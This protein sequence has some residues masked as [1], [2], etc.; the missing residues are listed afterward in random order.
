MQF[1]PLVRKVLGQKFGRL[2]VI[3]ELPA[4]PHVDRRAICKCD[5]GKIVNRVVSS[6][7]A[8]TKK[9]GTA[10]CGCFLDEFWKTGR[11]HTTHG[12]GK[13]SEHTIW[14]KMIQR[15]T[16]END[17]SYHKYGGRGIRVCDRWRWSFGDFYA[18]MGPRPTPQHSIERINN[19][20]NYK[21]SNCRWATKKEQARNRRSSRLITVGGV[22]MTLAEAAEKHGLTIRQLWSRLKLGWSL[23][24]ALSAPLKVMGHRRL[25]KK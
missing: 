21:P 1:H 4:I 22:R 13:P 8:H 19:N 25:Q 7:K 11:A 14:A 6:L 23:D 12:L 18:D 10:S 2:T 24:R 9:G 17:P 3:E 15:C 20:G 16:N 5:C